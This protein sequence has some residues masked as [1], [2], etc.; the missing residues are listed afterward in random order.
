MT[1][2]FEQNFLSFFSIIYVVR[3][4]KFHLKIRNKTFFRPINRLFTIIH[5]RFLAH[6]RT[7]L[8]S[9][10]RDGSSLDFRKVERTICFHYLHTCTLSSER[11]RWQTDDT[12]PWIRAK[13]IK[14]CCLPDLHRCFKWNLG[15]IIPFKRFSKCNLSIL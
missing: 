7:I 8:L 10:V 9:I 4:L 1:K 6:Y 14:N 3:L 2:K 12:R 15:K 5:D 13:R 11:K